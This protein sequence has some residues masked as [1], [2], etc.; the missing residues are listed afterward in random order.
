MRG[1]GG[2]A[3]KSAE[4]YDCIKPLTAEADCRGQPFSAVSV[5]A[6]DRLICTFDD[7][8]TVEWTA[9]VKEVSPNDGGH[10][11]FTITEDGD[12]CMRFDQDMQGRSPPVSATSDTS[13][14][15]NI[16]Q[17]CA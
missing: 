6:S 3:C 2:D 8:T 7:G 14:T 9:S 13:T 10:D 15:T 16:T 11:G 1:G 4:D 12:V 5:R 17:G